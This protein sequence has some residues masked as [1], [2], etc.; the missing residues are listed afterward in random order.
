MHYSNFLSSSSD[1]MQTHSRCFYLSLT[2]MPKSVKTLETSLDLTPSFKTSFDMRLGSRVLFRM[3]IVCKIGTVTLFKQNM[4]ETDVCHVHTFFFT[5]F[6]HRSCLLK[7]KNKYIRLSPSGL[8]SFY[9]FFN[10]WFKRLSF[11]TQF[12]IEL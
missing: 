6:L 8:N 2:L 1:L 7:V 5:D 12:E 10:F 4:T 3:W 9:Y 11:K